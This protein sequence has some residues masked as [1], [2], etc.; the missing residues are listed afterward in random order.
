[1]KKWKI[2]TLSSILILLIS[3]TIFFKISQSYLEKEQITEISIFGDENTRGEI[4]VLYRPGIT[5][6]QKDL[7]DNAI[8]ETIKR[9]W[10][11]SSTTISSQTITNLTKFEYVIII[12]PVYEQ[13]I[14][15]D[16]SKYLKKVV[17]NQT[18]IIGIVTSGS[19]HST[20][21]DNLNESITQANGKIVGGLSLSYI[22]F[23]EFGAKSKMSTLIT[24]SIE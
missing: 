12:T 3:T 24:N 23:P 17:F 16:V 1:V 13:K 7:N 2:I 4:L 19:K 20:Y 8:D 21:I 15:D 18:K 14:H 5:N 10:T 11:T 6:F 9:N 22:I